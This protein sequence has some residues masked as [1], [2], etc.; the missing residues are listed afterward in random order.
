[1]DISPGRSTLPLSNFELQ[2]GLGWLAQAHH[3]LSFPNTGGSSMLYFTR[4]FYF[5]VMYIQPSL[6]LRPK[7][8]GDGVHAVPLVR[9]RWE[10]LPLE[11]MAQVAPAVLACDLNALH[12]HGGVLVPLHGVRDL[13][14]ERRP[15][16]PT[17]E[18]ALRTA[19]KPYENILKNPAMST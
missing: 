10:A 5:N 13:F 6:L 1:M 9:G 4:Q 8:D 15:P 7:L 19:P 14:I 2:P 17:V 12:A 11:H 18:L 16:T 3:P